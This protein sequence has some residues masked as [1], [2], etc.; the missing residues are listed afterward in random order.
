MEQNPDL[1]ELREQIDAVDREIVRL[2]EERMAISEKIADVKERA[3][4]DIFDRKREE[5]KIAAVR[6]LAHD[7]S[8]RNDIGEFYGLLMAMSRRRQHA[9]LEQVKTDS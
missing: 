5:Q 1:E 6:E 3:G 9:V 2:F 8:N 4:K 7:E